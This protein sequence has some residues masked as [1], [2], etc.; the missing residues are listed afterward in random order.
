MTNK[1][2]QCSLAVMGRTMEL[3]AQ[4]WRGIDGVAGYR[5]CGLR[6]DDDATEP[7]MVWGAQCH[8]LGEDDIVAS[9]E[10]ASQA[11]G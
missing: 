9:L 6:E 3:R 8:G 11:W 1:N 4:G 7:G 2:I 10:M 5:Y